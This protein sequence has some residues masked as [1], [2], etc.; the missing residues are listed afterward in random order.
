MP[1]SKRKL[2]DDADIMYVSYSVKRRK[3]FG[4]YKGEWLGESSDKEHVAQLVA[5]RL[6]LSV[7]ALIELT[8]ARRG[9]ARLKHQS[10]TKDVLAARCSRHQYITYDTHHCK[11]KFTKAGVRSTRWATEAA[12]VIYACKVLKCTPDELIAGR[13]ADVRHKMK[14]MATRAKVMTRVMIGVLPADLDDWVSRCA[15]AEDLFRTE[16]GMLVIDA[17]WKTKPARDLLERSWLQVERPD[18]HGQATRLSRIR[19]IH[20]VVW[21]AAE[22]L[23]DQ[24]HA[25]WSLNCG[26]FAYASG[27]LAW[28]VNKS[29]IT[30]STHG[31]LVLG[32]LRRS[33]QQRLK[34]NKAARVCVFVCV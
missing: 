22:L 5:N 31:K 23:S 12:A 33:T 11:W 25:L 20:K 16:Q 13:K 32:Q 19:R 30:K 1:A 21:K 26:G 2:K 18:T 27:W 6:N 8:R 15:C 10:Q 28:L 34:P 14:E 17:L 3:Y 29:I 9:G 4:Q 24:E 7:E